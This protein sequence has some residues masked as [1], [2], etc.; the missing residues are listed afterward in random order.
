M[1][2]HAVLVFILSGLPVSRAH[3]GHYHDPSDR[4]N[5]TVIPGGWQGSGQYSLSSDGNVFVHGDWAARAVYGETSGRRKLIHTGCSVLAIEPT[6]D[7]DLAVLCMNETGVVFLPDFNGNPTHEVEV[8]AE[9]SGNRLRMFGGKMFTM[10][11][12]TGTICKYD[13]TETVFKET[14]KPGLEISSAWLWKSDYVKF[15]SFDL[16][17]D[18]CVLYYWNA[19][20]GIRTTVGRY[21]FG[22]KTLKDFFPRGICTGVGDTGHCGGDLRVVD[23]T[24]YVFTGEGSTRRQMPSK[25]PQSA[26]SPNGKVFAIELSS[27]EPPKMRG[28]GLRHPWAVAYDAARKEFYVGDVGRNRWEEITAISLSALELGGVNFGWPVFEGREPVP[29]M[30]CLNEQYRRVAFPLVTIEHGAC[31]YTGKHV[32]WLELV[33]VNSL[34]IVWIVASVFR[35]E[36]L[37]GIVLY[38]YALALTSAQLVW[39]PWAVA[40]PSGYAFTETGALHL[41]PF[42]VRVGNNNRFDVQRTDGFRYAVVVYAFAVLSWAF[43]FF[44][45]VGNRILNAA[46]GV[47][48]ALL[49]AVA[50]AAVVLGV[51]CGWRPGGAHVAVSGACVLL[52]TL[53]SVEGVRAGP[54]RLARRERARSPRSGGHFGMRAHSRSY[55]LMERGERR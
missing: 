46:L 14:L 54:Q 7:G 53:I 39:L 31:K 1:R 42:T 50:L 12:A 34:L 55:S 8:A 40:E 36:A 16:E 17:S 32:F 21:C 23:G 44:L 25:T 28:V 15:I 45:L 33:L 49:G 10:S 48:N 5:G 47:A 52:S 26:G 2:H 30:M 3:A 43:P 11:S 22:K 19:G 35:L 18:D 6:S 9:C 13:E 37:R 38:A 4:C 20:P 24:A 29:S 51:R 27:N 41:V